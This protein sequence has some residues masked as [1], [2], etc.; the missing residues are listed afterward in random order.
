[1]MGFSTKY[2]FGLYREKK[3]EISRKKDG[4]LS[5]YGFGLSKKI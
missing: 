5:K 2:R 1:M 3:K 4:G